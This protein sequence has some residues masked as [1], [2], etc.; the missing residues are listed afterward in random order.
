[1]RSLRRRRRRRLRHHRGAARHAAARRRAAC[2]H[3]HRAQHLWRSGGRRGG[4]TRCLLRLLAAAECDRGL[5]LSGPLDAP[6]RLHVAAT[7]V[8]PT[9]GLAC[10]FEGAVRQTAP[11]SFAGE[12]ALVCDAPPLPEGHRAPAAVA[13]VASTDGSAFG[14]GSAP[15]VYYDAAAPPSLTAVAPRL[16][17]L[18]APA[19]VLTLSRA[20]IAPTGSLLLCRFAAVA[21]GECVLDDDDGARLL[22]R[23]GHCALRAAA[24]RR[25][26]DAPRQLVPGRR[27]LVGRARGRVTTRTRRRRC[28]PCVPPRRGPTRVRAS[29]SRTT[30]RPPKLLVH[31]WRRAADAGDGAAVVDGAMPRPLSNRQHRRLRLSLGGS[32]GV[33]AAALPLRPTMQRRRRRCRRR[34]P[35]ARRVA[36]ATPLWCAGRRADRRPPL[37]LPRD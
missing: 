32:G 9:P 23:P 35:T 26:G 16:L 8:A 12:G 20:N 5:P 24:R 3:A 37:P 6:T 28:R 33:S 36:A 29:S 10:A 13:V 4:G 2:R 31:V 22:R 30:L 11:A 34:R 21:D 18:D 27:R 25:P 19:T 14:V 7:N 1:M 17:A 15:Y